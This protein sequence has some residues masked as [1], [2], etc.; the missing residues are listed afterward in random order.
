[1]E[2]KNNFRGLSWTFSPKYENVW[3]RI[4]KGWHAE[5][6]LLREAHRAISKD[7][8]ATVTLLNKSNIGLR[9]KHELGPP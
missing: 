8:R 4:T 3:S 5:P 6:A 1:M 7:V 2:A 9:K